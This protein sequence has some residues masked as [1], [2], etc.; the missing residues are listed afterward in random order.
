MGLDYL[1]FLCKWNRLHSVAL[2]SV[3]SSSKTGVL[4]HVQYFGDA[5]ERGYIFEKNMVPFTGED[6]YQDL[7]Q[8][9]KQPASRSVHKKVPRL[10]PLL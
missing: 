7:C 2:Y 5:P 1:D 9:K 8:C 3:A 10:Y 4:Y 6:Q